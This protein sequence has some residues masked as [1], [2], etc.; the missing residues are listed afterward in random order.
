VQLHVEW[1]AERPTV[2]LIKLT[3]LDSW[4]HYNTVTQYFINNM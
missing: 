1:R 2:D 4:S 3:T